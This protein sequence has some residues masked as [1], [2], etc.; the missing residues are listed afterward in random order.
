M[1]IEIL[2]QTGN[3]NHLGRW[4]REKKAGRSGYPLHGGAT[5]VAHP[6]PEAGVEQL[7]QCPL[8]PLLASASGSPGEYLSALHARQAR[9]PEV[10]SR[11]VGGWRRSLGSQS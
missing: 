3:E 7:G 10:Q 5:A 1:V 6:G 9:G 11:W 8:S 2:A 4:R